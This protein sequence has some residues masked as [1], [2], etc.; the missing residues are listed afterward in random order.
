MVIKFRA[1]QREG[2]KPLNEFGSLL[3]AIH[4]LTDACK[5]QR[6]NGKYFIERKEFPQEE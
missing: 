1:M 5:G 3:A 2:Y 4:I 6:R